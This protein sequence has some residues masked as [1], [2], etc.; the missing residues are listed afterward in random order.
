MTEK[1]TVLISTWLQPGVPRPAKY[2]AAS[3]ASPRMV[4]AVETASTLR[5]F[6][7]GLK[8]GA[9]ENFFSV[10]FAFSC[11]DSLRECILDFNFPTQVKHGFA[12]NLHALA[13]E[14]AK[15]FTAAPR[16]LSRVKPG[17]GEARRPVRNQG[18]M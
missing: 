11:G 1:F 6:S 8:P 15:K 4:Q 5:V 2:L 13:G 7:T 10:F 9:N 16:N 18:A 14:L 12:A 17:F 3:A